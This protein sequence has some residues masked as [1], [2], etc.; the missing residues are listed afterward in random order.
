MK[1]LI[2][3]VLLIFVGASIVKLVINANQ[4]EKPSDVAPE[5]T[6]GTQTVV[7]YFHGNVRCKTCNTIEAYTNKTV[8]GK[9]ADQVKDGVL[10][11]RVI[12]MD[13][14]GNG[15]YVDDYQL[16]SSSVVV[17]QVKEGTE[18]KWRRLDEVWDLVRD[19]AAFA[20]LIENETRSAMEGSE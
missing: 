11:M 19:E 10:V 4:G 20:T 8:Q 12:N 17:S 2:S 9:F 18:V 13:E 14:P 15:H 7:Y 16:T 6:A 5:M 3:I 1:R